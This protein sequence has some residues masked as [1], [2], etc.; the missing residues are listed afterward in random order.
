MTH[1]PR[2]VAVGVT[3]GVVA[4]IPFGTIAR[5]VVGHVLWIGG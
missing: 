3:V 5:S 1:L 2:V 4:V